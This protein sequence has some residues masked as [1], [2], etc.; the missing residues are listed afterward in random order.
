[1][2]KHNKSA[3]DAGGKAEQDGW[4]DLAG[5]ALALERE[6]RKFEQLTTTARKMPIDTRKG[7]ERAAQA[8]VEAAHAQEQVSASLTA[9]IQAI[10]AARERHE[11]NVK[12]LAARGE[13]IRLRA[14]ELGP[15]YERYAALGDEGQAINGL[16]QEAAAMQRA[17]TTPDKVIALVAALAGIEERMAKLMDDARELGKAAGAA[18][19]SELSE[20]SDSLRQQVA[21]TRNKLGLLRKGL[22]A[23]AG[24]VP[25]SVKIEGV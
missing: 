5:T 19:L 14:A 13:E 2:S 23:Q 17:A 10:Q 22:L 12:V 25:D 3:R 4:G 20:Q 16:V 7:L 24:S 6:L 9:L 18:S 8:T 1:V 11:A 21:A 15:L